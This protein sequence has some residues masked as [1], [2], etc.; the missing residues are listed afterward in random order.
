MFR[1]FTPL[2]LSIIILS[3]SQVRADSNTT[4]SEHYKKAKVAYVAGDFETALK[5]F[6]EA[7][8]ISG[9]ADLLYNLAIC[10]EK[11]GQKDKAI[12]FYELYLEEKPD[13]EDAEQI[14]SRVDSLNS[15][16]KHAEQ[17][18]ETPAQKL[19]KK[20]ITTSSDNQKSIPKPSEKKRRNI[21]W[22]GIII[23]AGGVILGT[24]ALTAIS[25]YK[26]HKDLESLCA[27]DC[28]DSQVKPARRKSLAADLQF[29]IGAGITAGGFIWWLLSKDERQT[30][31]TLTAWRVAPV[32]WNNGGV[33][34]IEGK[35]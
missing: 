33:L 30:A 4:A 27:P 5:E 13:A 35:F 16:E 21:V 29:V 1:T 3:G 14:K 6:T 15:P 11:I 10:S 24:G 19:A 7:Y 28:S 23:G 25:A 26:K 34:A 17:P 12:A 32:V 22:P 31:G 20:T 9:K 2:L 18:T 8:N